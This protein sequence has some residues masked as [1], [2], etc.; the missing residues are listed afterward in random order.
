M[1]MKQLL[2]KTGL[3]LFLFTLI[4][5][6]I[7]LQNETITVHASTSSSPAARTGSPGDN[8]LTC[9]NSCHTGAPLQTLNNIINSN[10]PSG[11]YVPGNT[12]TITATFNRPGHTKLGFEISPQL[13]NGNQVGTLI[14]GPGTVLV[15]SGKYISH[16]SSGTSAPGGN[17]TWTFQ[18]TAPVAGTGAFTFYGAFNATNALSNSSG[19]S[20]FVS[21]LTV[22]EDNSVSIAENKELNFQVYPVPASENININWTPG[23][24]NNEFSFSIYDIKSNLILNKKIN[25]Q[26]S[27][28]GKITLSIKELNLPEGIYILYVS[29]N[30]EIKSTKKIIIN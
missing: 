9:L 17:K 15:G 14:A 29:E 4:S 6:L 12:Y 27:S 2:K 30:N 25:S 19:D 23:I 8:N 18:W 26:E 5:F 13:L 16:N 20:I 7:T 24:I 21:T 28:S 11:G 22:N 10:I 3:L 1:I